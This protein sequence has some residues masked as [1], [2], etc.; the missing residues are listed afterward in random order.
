MFTVT[1]RASTDIK[2]VVNFSDT[3]RWCEMFTVC[4]P[5]FYFICISLENF[6]VYFGPYCY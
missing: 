3:K 6:Q 1:R 4:N 2:R 5:H